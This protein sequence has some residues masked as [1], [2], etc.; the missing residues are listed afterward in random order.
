MRSAKLCA[1]L[2]VL[3]LV[4]TCG[5]DDSTDPANPTRPAVRQIGHL[6]SAIAPQMLENVHA[7]TFSVQGDS[8]ILLQGATLSQLTHSHNEQLRAT[9]RAGYTIVLL[10][11]TTEHIEA[12]HN[13]IGD[14]VP[15]TLQEGESIL[16]YTLRRD[17]RVAKATLVMNVLLSPLRTSGG[18]AELTGLLDNERAL[19][20]SVD[21]VVAELSQP[22]NVAERLP[23][24]PNQNVD[25]EDNP[26]QNTTLATQTGGVYNTSVNVYALHSCLENADRY[27]VT[28]EADWTATDA[29]FQS[30]ATELGS[31]SMYYDQA[32]DLMV[33]ANWADDPTLTYCSSPSA[34]SSDADICR[35]INY[36]LEYDLVM[37]P[38]STGTV[39]QL[40]AAPPATQG[41]SVTVQ[42][43]FSFS[44]GGGVNV[45]GMG[46]GAGLSA[47]ASWSDTT[48]TTVPPLLLEVGNQGNQGAFWKFKYCT[49]GEEPDADS[50]CTSHVQTVKDVC[51]AQFGDFSGTN[52]QQ[53]QTSDGK[54]SNSV[55][56][57]HWKQPV[58]SRSGTTFDI[59]VSFT[60][61]I[62]TTTANLWGSSNQDR[63]NAGCNPFNCDCVSKTTAT[64]QALS[65][66]FK[67]P[68]PSTVCK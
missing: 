20:R 39:L 36:P 32:N 14:G 68:Y 64:R 6:D 43:G 47:S 33:V 5:G 3:C 1:L 29:K 17:R 11:A 53:G 12:L 54:L 50:N 16:A 24:D 58:A 48:S 41:Q 28:A 38:P 18:E 23:R 49:H 4:V 59:Q 22:P 37:L 42:N 9:Y 2:G 13:V 25:L 66:T 63:A 8:P 60:P 19:R 35:Y 30:A 55:Q 21:R 46:P 40:N 57:I 34:F 62:A 31:T 65:V 7:V 51:R 61:V 15:A 10:D 67:V 26:V 27:V 44:V 45:S 52:P 56:G